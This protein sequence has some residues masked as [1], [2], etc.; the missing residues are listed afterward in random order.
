MLAHLPDGI[1]PGSFNKIMVPGDCNGHPNMEG[2]LYALNAL[3]KGDLIAAAEKFYGRQS[4]EYVRI[5]W[6][7]EDAIKDADLIGALYWD[8]QFIPK[9]RERAAWLAEHGF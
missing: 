7:V 1:T 9:M 5:V 2:K 4:E 3:R 8:N 6:L